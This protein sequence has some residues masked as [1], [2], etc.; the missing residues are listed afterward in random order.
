MNHIKICFLFCF[1]SSFGSQWQMMHPGDEWRAEMIDYWTT[2]FSVLR[3]SD[4]EVILPTLECSR[5]SS[6]N[7][8]TIYTVYKYTIKYIVQYVS[9][10]DNEEQRKRISKYNKKLIFPNIPT[11]LHST[12]QL[13]QS[14]HRFLPHS[15]GE[16]RLQSARQFPLTHHQNALAVCT[17][18]PTLSYQ[19]H[20]HSPSPSF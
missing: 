10:I 11:T 17:K 8:E 2:L 7:V 15:D 5:A 3:C 18:S 20:L 19:Q 14:K 1:G 16:D 4:W 9:S 13:A 12:P 6:P